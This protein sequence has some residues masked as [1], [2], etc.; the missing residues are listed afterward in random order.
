AL[1]NCNRIIIPHMCWK[2]CGKK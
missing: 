2:K 1:C